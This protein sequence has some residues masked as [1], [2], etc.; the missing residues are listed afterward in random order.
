MKAKHD[1]KEQALV[2]GIQAN[3]LQK[4]CDKIRK[5][6]TKRDITVDQFINQ[7]VKSR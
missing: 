3:E 5:Q 1:P 2:V 7:Y 4:E 6:F